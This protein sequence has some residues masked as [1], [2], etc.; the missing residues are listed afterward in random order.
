MKYIGAHVSAANGAWHAPLNA[1]AIGANAFA[2]FTKNQQQWFAGPIEE[3]DVLRFREECGKTGIVPRFIL[4]HD[5]Y[6]INLGNPDP[7]KFDKSLKA[8]IHEVRRVEQL[9]LDRLNFH[10]G[11]HMNAVSEDE[12]MAQI[13]AA[14]RTTIAETEKT[15]LVVEVTAGQ[16]TSVG[17]TFEHLAR[18]LEL[19]GNPARTGVCIDTC[20]IF[21]AGYDIRTRESYE[22]TME[23]FDRIVGFGS[24]RGVHLNDAKSELGSRVDRHNCLGK[25]NIGLDAFGFLMNDSRF[26]DVPLIL[27]TPD[28]DLWAEEIRMLR[29]MVRGENA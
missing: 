7:E 12:C 28:P 18:I 2:L 14:M 10:P 9:G 15:V 27:E 19:A 11:N 17:Y 22:A 3:K 21:A 20:H 1:A 24:L 25:G 23:K 4:P 5:S 26:D 13:A 6:L 29:S 16:G 8:F